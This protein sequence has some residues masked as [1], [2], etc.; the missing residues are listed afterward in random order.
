MRGSRR[1]RFAAEHQAGGRWGGRGRAPR[2]DLL[3][4]LPVAELDL[5]ERLAGEKT[6][7]H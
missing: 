1:A 3:K 6:S 5:G 7:R 4:E 2:A